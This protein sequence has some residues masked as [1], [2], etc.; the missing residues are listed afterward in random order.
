[1]NISFD[2]H[3]AIRNN[4]Q[5]KNF[6]LSLALRHDWGTLKM[7]YS[8]PEHSQSPSDTAQNCVLG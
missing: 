7:I 2:I 5:N 8:N 4:Y 3:I 6:A 1:M